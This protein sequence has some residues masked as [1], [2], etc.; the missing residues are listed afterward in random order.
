MVEGGFWRGVLEVGEVWKQD[1]D[2]GGNERLVY[3]VD[4]GKESLWRRMM[5]LGCRLKQ[6]VGLQWYTEDVGVSV[7]THVI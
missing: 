3:F 7:L 2:E 5:C 6:D 4:R 1:D